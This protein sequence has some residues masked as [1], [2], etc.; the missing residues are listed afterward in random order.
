MTNISVTRKTKASPEAC[1]DL[2]SDFANIDF[3]N[4]GVKESR[5]LNGSSERGVG[6][7]RQCD[8]TD[9][10]NFIRERIIDW[11]EGKS[12]TVSIYEGTMPLKNTVATLKIE[13]DGAGTILAMEMEYIPKFGP[14]GAL[15]NVVMLRRMM[16]K[17]MRSVV[18]GLDEKAVVRGAKAA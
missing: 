1:W 7:V 5:L 15:M 8:L 12:Y 9:G 16:E 2:L 3:F 10:K 13:P 4:P 17:S 6:A 11:Q 18:Q 14:L